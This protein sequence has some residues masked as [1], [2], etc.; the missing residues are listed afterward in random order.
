MLYEIDLT[1]E[2]YWPKPRKHVLADVQ[3]S[4]S[5]SDELYNEHKDVMFTYINGEI[6]WWH[7]SSDYSKELQRYYE[8]TV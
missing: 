2:L 3:N 8:G 4:L 7:L 5:A 1:P 6:V